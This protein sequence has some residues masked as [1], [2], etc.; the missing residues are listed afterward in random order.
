ML[1]ALLCALLV[2][3]TA[4]RAC[5]AGWYLCA[6]RAACMDGAHACTPIPPE[7]VVWDNGC[8]RCAAAA[9]SDCKGCLLPLHEPF[10][11]E[12]DVPQVP[13]LPGQWAETVPRNARVAVRVTVSDAYGRGSGVAQYTVSLVLPP[14][15]F[16]TAIYGSASSTLSIPAALAVGELEGSRM[17]LGESFASVGVPAWRSEVPLLVDN[18][19]WFTIPS[20]SDTMGTWSEHIP[21]ARILLPRETIATTMMNAQLT[22]CGGT[23]VYHVTGIVARLSTS[24]GH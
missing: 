20:S 12:A 23:A 22:T 14:C 9:M 10:C 15:M 19:A 3:T 17:L 11:A 16:L 13:V 6:A 24:G 4:G 21:I 2:D 18:G 8:H 7:C 1:R 5:G